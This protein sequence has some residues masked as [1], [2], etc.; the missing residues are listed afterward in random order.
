M[1]IKAESVPETG[2]SVFDGSQYN[3]IGCLYVPE[4]SAVSYKAAEQWKDWKNIAAIGGGDIVIHQCEAP[5]ISYSNGQ[6]SF[7]SSTENAQ[8]HYTIDDSDIRTTPTSSNG[9]VDLTATYYVTV[10][11]TAEGYTNSETVTAT[12]CWIDVD[13]KTEGITNSV[14]HLNAKALLIQTNDGFIKV[15][16]M[17]DGQQMNVYLADGKQVAM[18]TSTNGSA[19]VA[20]NIKKGTPVLVKLGARTVK[21]IMK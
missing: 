15:D 16:G 10:F 3:T 19:S 9:I 21:L 5:T 4:K 11:A 20:T 14:A 13:P 7:A 1:T 12:L 6:L 8:Y 18:A 2:Y 17:E